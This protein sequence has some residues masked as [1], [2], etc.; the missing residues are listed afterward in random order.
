MHH[1]L[2]HPSKE[3]IQ[4]A[5]KHVKDFPHVEI[6]KEH[7]CPGCAQGK[8]TNKAFP[9]SNL[10]ASAPFELIYLDLK[11]F[12]IESYHKFKYSIVFYDNFTSHAWTVNLC[13]KDA[14]LPAVKHF[15]AAVENKY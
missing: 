1:R 15:L 13:S 6:P 12:P 5:G 4:K 8:M 2:A 11:Q 14:A 10:R 7:V 3:V 9:P